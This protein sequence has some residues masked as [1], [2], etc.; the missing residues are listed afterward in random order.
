MPGI[1]QAFSRTEIQRVK[2]F[3]L[4]RID[5]GPP[6]A[7]RHRDLQPIPQR[8]PRQQAGEAGTV[9]REIRVLTRL[10]AHLLGN[11]LVRHRTQ[12][13][14][15]LSRDRHAERGAILLGGPSRFP[16]LQRVMLG[17]QVI[18]H[19]P[20]VA[21]W[22]HRGWPGFRGRDR[23]RFVRH[24]SGL[25][26][27]RE[28]SAV[29]VHQKAGRLC[30]RAQR[31]KLCLVLIAKT[32]FAFQGGARHHRRTRRWWRGRRDGLRLLAVHIPRSTEIR[33]CRRGCPGLTHRL[34]GLIPLRIETGVRGRL[35]GRRGRSRVL[36]VSHC[37]GFHR[38]RGAF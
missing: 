30:L 27:R 18:E 3:R 7:R 25:R 14:F 10:V 9:Q 33:G 2:M 34:R 8:H 17:G 1:P 35:D 22:R 6:G 32:S 29:L 24:R 26:W 36:W 16:S 11:R 12:D 23:R 37:V 38:R 20:L 28:A 31:I 5:R 19:C 4:R 21:L 13:P 15:V